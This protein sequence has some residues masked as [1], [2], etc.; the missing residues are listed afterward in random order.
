MA[1]L[2][3]AKHEAFADAV[4]RG[5]TAIGAYRQVYGAEQQTAKKQSYLLTKRPEV[6]TRIEELRAQSE[7]LPQFDFGPA[8]KYLS[9]VMS[10][11]SKDSAS[12]T[13]ARVKAIETA[14]RVS[15]RYNP[16]STD[17]PTP[18]PA[19]SIEEALARLMHEPPPSFDDD[20]SASTTRP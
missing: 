18:P 6:R 13:N 10:G 7:G 15:G 3:N 12:L 5:E 11:R 2:E 4:A 8:F 9:D 1:A 16:K 14:L 20:H 19:G 17:Q